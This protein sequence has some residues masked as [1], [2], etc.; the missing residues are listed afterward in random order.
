MNETSI[1]SV[2]ES[3]ADH[4]DSTRYNKWRGVMEFLETISP[5]TKL[6]DAGCGNGKYLS[7]RKDCEVYACDTCPSLIMSAA[8]KHTHANI[9]LANIKSLPYFDNTFDYIICIAVLHHLTTE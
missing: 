8:K 6:L 7:V 2:Y 1:Q 5:A 9:I 3:I 4:F